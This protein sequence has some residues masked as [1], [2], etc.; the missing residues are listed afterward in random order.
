ME[1]LELELLTDEKAIYRYYP[2]GGKEYG[3]VSLMR[4]T[5]ERIHDMPCP[6][7]GSMYAR[8][9]WDRLDECQ[10][11]GNYPQ[12]TMVAWY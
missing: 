9:A 5:G 3:I 1:W 8:Q 7:T 12:R 11:T 6:G 4:K 10:E 2:E